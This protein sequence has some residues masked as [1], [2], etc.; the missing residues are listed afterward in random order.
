MHV[1]FQ[2]RLSDDLYLRVFRVGKVI[3]CKSSLAC[4]CMSIYMT[5]VRMHRALKRKQQLEAKEAALLLNLT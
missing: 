5:L 1:R 3:G 4:C 2:A